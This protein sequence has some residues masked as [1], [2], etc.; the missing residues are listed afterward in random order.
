MLLSRNTVVIGA[1]VITALSFVLGYFV[2]YKGGGISEGDKPASGLVREG[3]AAR[4]QEEKRVME[5]SAP[6]ETAG[7]QQAPPASAL[8]QSG[9]LPLSPPIGPGE[10]VPEAA[11]SRRADATASEAAGE[12]AQRK[13]E[14]DRPERAPERLPGILEARGTASPGGQSA[15]EGH[16]GP[17]QKEHPGKNAAEPKAGR[18]GREKAAGKASPAAGTVNVKTYTVQI[19][20][21][22][23]REGAEQL[24][25][26]LQ[27]RGYKPYI[28][29]AGQ[30]DTYFRVRLGAYKDRKEAERNAVAFS[31]KTGLPNFVTQK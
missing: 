19:G 29:D 4:Q 15:G 20:A 2:G 21:F 24:L 16:A 22:P 18:Q 31:K 7:D 9:Q 28:V 5:P 13:K 25:Q 11:P 17:A 30:G 6:P 27:A 10:I 8:P 14:A 23:S 3:E 26:N 1:M 12:Q